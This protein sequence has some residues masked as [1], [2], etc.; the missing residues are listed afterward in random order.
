MPAAG[1]A[2][3]PVPS[4][5]RG[6]DSRDPDRPRRPVVPLVLGVAGVL[7]A[8]TAIV[9]TWHRAPYPLWLWLPV[10]SAGA[11]FV[12][13]G[14]VLRVRR[15]ANGT[16]RLMMLVGFTWYLGD[17]QLADSPTLFA[18]GFCC[19]HLTYAAIGHLVLAL[20]AGRLYHRHERPVVALLYIAS[21]GTQIVRYAAE[22]PPQPQQWGDPSAPHSVW[23]PIGSVTVA[24][25][26]VLTAALVVR[27]WSTAGR[28]VRRA[29]A[30]VWLTMLA[31]GGV[32][33]LGAGAAMLRAAPD[34]QQ[35][36][37]L[38]Y[39][40]GLIVTPV[41]LVAG[42]V[43]VRMARVRVADLVVRLEESAEPA[44][45]EEALAQ[46]LGDPGLELWFPREESASD[47]DGATRYVRAD[48]VA[49]EADV[50]GADGLAR[51][52]S[53]VTPVVRRG[54][55][56]A[57]LVHDPALR[58]Q[59][60][61]VDTVLAAA[62]LAL[63]NARLLAAQRARLA[64][65]RASRARLVLAADAE[66]RRIQRDLHDGVQHRLLV[67]SML[68]DRARATG[69]RPG[70]RGPTGSKESDLAAASAH[71]TEVLHELRALA[72]GI[73]PPALA[74]QGLAAAVEVLAERAPLPVVPEIPE[75]RL[76]EHLE[77]T[78]YFIVTEALSNVYKHAGAT[79]AR[80]RVDDGAGGLL[81][82]EVTDDGTGGADPAE[83]TGLRGLEDRVG[84]LGGRLRVHSPRGAGTRLVAELPCGS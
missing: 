63:D 15:P 40:L 70:G 29:Y 13:C 77:R 67:I 84:A 17:L 1:V 44:H 54:E 60:P 75:R 26:T 66:R 7:V 79:E 61:L 18:I 12:V 22:Y 38:G 2:P 59:R 48:G 25:L 72:E 46:A 21:V 74:E 39:A 57:L 80:V 33:V 71:L 43:R 28:P 83:G 82:I 30:P 16:G 14:A 55:L 69:A 37:L 6:S 53:C 58:E 32:V 11:S 64:E 27:R 3:T 31:L 51:D 65:V 23:S 50:D 4:W 49:A 56:L 76:P 34:V 73:H 19:Y 5:P 47:G 45:V 81:V 68:V 9:T 20:P 78:A 35:F 62:G 10:Q 42:L 24:A 8:S 52:G 36:A 41:A